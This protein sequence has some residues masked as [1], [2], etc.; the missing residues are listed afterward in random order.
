MHR[1]PA[2]PAFVFTFALA[3]VGATACATA[4]P[5]SGDSARDRE[6]SVQLSQAG[7]AL[8]TTCRLE[9]VGLPCDPDGAGNATECDG[10]CWVNAG[11]E[12]SCVAVFDIGLQVTDLN[13]RICGDEQGT[14]CSR[15][16]ENGQ[17]VDKNARLGTA[18]RPAA[19]STTCD[20]VC[21]LRGGEATCDAVDVCEDVGLSPDSC[22]LTACNFD[23]FEQGCTT[24]EL[25]NRVCEA[26]QP[27][28]DGGAT[29]GDASADASIEDA[30]TR[31]ASLN[32]DASTPLDAS[33][34]ALS[35]AQTSHQEAGASSTTRGS[36]ATS[37][38]SRAVLDAGVDAGPKPRVPARVVGGACTLKPSTNSGLVGYVA[39][40]LAG[41][42]LRRRSSC[43]HVAKRRD[44]LLHL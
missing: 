9:T 31:D 25:R 6:D 39:L 35:S 15:S 28:A 44:E 19:N 21:T 38:S 5:P 13:G 23:T 14:D 16:C 8:T 18:C 22:R 32:N 27:D 30:S 42:L 43:D 40:I 10:V 3:V 29:D 34:S 24:Y 37:T 36:A 17:C 1:P 2:S 20:G 33:T 11:A 7:S 12:V 41:V 4:T 26:S